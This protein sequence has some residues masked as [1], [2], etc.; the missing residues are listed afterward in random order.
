LDY[1]AHHV[2]QNIC[3]TQNT[4]QK[5]AYTTAR[6]IKTSK[7][8]RCLRMY[9]ASERHCCWKLLWIVIN[10]IVLNKRT[11]LILV[12][13]IQYSIFKPSLHNSMLLTLFI[14]F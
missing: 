1:K 12:C 11:K 5:A 13:F 14:Q 8:E 4:H 2:K 9:V 6:H 10:C 3:F 7:E